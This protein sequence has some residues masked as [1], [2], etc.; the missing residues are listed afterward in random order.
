ML[1]TRLHFIEGTHT[2][3]HIGATIKSH[4]HTVI[5]GSS[6]RQPTQLPQSVV[7]LLLYKTISNF[8]HLPQ[9]HDPGTSL[10]STSR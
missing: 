5:N 8:L 7:S 6:D 4:T 10:F 2:T 1:I 3:Q 9:A